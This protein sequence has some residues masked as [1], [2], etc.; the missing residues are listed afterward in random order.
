MTDLTRTPLPRSPSGAVT[1]E[2]LAPW[3]ELVLR[4][5]A[6]RGDVRNPQNDFSAGLVASGTGVTL[7]AQAL[8]DGRTVGVPTLLSKIGDVGRAA[9]QRF[10]PIVNAGNRL[11]A[12]NINPLTSTGT[13]T[14]AAIQIAAHTVQYGFGTVSYG[15]GSISG[16][17]PLT[18]Y[19]VYASDPTYAGGAVAYTATE[20]PQTVVSND[21]YYYVGSIETANSTPEGTVT[22]ATNANPCAVTVVGHPFSNGDQVT[23]EDVEGMTELNGNTYTATV[24]GVD[25]FTIGVNSTAYGVYTTGGI[26]SRVA[27]PTD[28]SGGGGGWDYQIP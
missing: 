1:W 20:T 26:A 19:F 2:A 6:G 8:P 18:G 3:M 13:A 15:A 11:S 24:T 7:G 16:L 4:E 5:I 9:D 21:G 17:D 22:A 27:P 14:T 28:G 12:Q 10:L 23:F 25:T